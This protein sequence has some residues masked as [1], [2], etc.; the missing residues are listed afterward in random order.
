MR[1][2]KSTQ[3]LKEIVNKWQNDIIIVRHIREMTALTNSP[4]L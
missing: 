3:I 2:K 4:G 1:G